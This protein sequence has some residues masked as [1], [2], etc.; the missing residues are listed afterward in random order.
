[1]N[2]PRGPDEAKA[3]LLPRMENPSSAERGSHSRPLLRVRQHPWVSSP[4]SVV[5][6]TSS[7][8]GSAAPAS[9]IAGILRGGLGPDGTRRAK[10]KDLPVDDPAIGDEWAA[11]LEVEAIRWP[12]AEGGTR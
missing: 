7:T 11:L 3:D 8:C 5:S 1:M 2:R 10:D 9:P 6:S 4:C 12:M